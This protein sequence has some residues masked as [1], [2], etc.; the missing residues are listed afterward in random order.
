M[1]QET[2]KQDLATRAKGGVAKGGGK[3]LADILS[4]ERTQK[5]LERAAANHL[6]ADRLCRLALSLSRQRGLA[7]C[8]PSS[9]LSCVMQS[10]Q[11]GLEPVLGRCYYVP[12]KNK[13]T[14]N[15]EA[16]FQMG[17]QGLIELARRSGELKMIYAEI[18][19][20]N[21]EFEYHLGL[22]PELT[23]TPS[24]G[25]RGQA[26]G[27]YSVAHYKDGGYN[28][29]YLTANDVQ[30]IKTRSQAG[31]SGPWKTDL[32][33]MWKKT[34]IKALRPY[35]PLSVQAV[36]ETEPGVMRPADYEDIITVD[37]ETGEVLEETE[38]AE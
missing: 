27:V 23:H 10:A 6:D 8:T 24:D 21:D 1:T 34:A 22:Q 29:A 19:Y 38:G 16:T 20:A 30:K 14:G 33:M 17:Y 35:L 18:V 11:L 3:T 15:K 28:F 2:L 25:D 13:H 26:I 31:D 36:V 32:E 12:Y 9:I 4:N 7:E 37:T 5:E